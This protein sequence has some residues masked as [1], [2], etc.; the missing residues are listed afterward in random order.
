MHLK[1]ILDPLYRAARS[2]FFK[3]ILV[4]RSPLH[5]SG[6]LRIGKSIDTRIFLASNIANFGCE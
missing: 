4:K 6:D 1:V 5:F 2:V 3:T